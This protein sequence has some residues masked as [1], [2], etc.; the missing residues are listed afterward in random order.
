MLLYVVTIDHPAHADA[1]HK[2]C[3]GPR[4]PLF[5]RGS[6]SWGNPILLPFSELSSE[7]FEARY[8]FKSRYVFG[9]KSSPYFILHRN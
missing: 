9:L 8:Y 6:T 2:G 4:L 1:F 5:F 7:T 3:N